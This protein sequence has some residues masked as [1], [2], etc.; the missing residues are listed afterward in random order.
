MSRTVT[1]FKNFLADS[2]K[3]SYGKIFSEVFSLMIR[4]KSFPIYYFTRYIYKKSAGNHKDY[5]SLKLLHQ[6]WSNDFIH[7]QNCCNL[8]KN[9]LAFSQYCVQNNIPAVT[10]LMWNEGSVFYDANQ[11]SKEVSTV[12]DLTEL[13]LGLDVDLF[14]KPRDGIK[15]E[16][17]YRLKKEDL[18]ND[19]LM[20]EV[21]SLVKENNFI[22]QKLIIQ[23]KAINEIYSDSI[24]T[25]RI[26]TYRDKNEKTHVLTAFMRFGMGGK[27]TDNTGTDGF[28]IPLNLKTGHF[29]KYGIQY[30]NVNT[31]PIESHP[32]TKVKFENRMVPFF[33]EILALAH[34]LSKSFVDRLVGWD[35]AITENGPIVIEGNCDYAIAGQDIINKGYKS[36]PIFAK[37]LNESGLA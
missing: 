34:V 19:A 10:N 22:F 15:G 27:V 4:D 35:V 16:S 1:Q 37:M 18:N 17:C 9:K 32:D 14:A 20:Q 30:L 23:H 31:Q 11:T 7:Q 6:I 26:D 12:K 8:L 28:I 5:I 36:H 25:I 33:N 24:N 21:F 3:K 13:L 2:E 29:E